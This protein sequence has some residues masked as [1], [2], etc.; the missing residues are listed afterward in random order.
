MYGTDGTKPE[1][2]PAM[3]ANREIKFP[4]LLDPTKAFFKAQRVGAYPVATLVDASGTVVWQGHTALRKQF[5]DACE[6]EIRTLLKLAPKK[7]AGP[8]ST[9]D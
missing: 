2:M 6:V 8:E 3:L 4:A 1:A 7:E 9:D 5:A